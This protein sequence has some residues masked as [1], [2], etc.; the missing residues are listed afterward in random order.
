MEGWWL[1]LIIEGYKDKIISINY[2][3]VVYIVVFCISSMDVKK[4]KKDL[5]K[6]YYVSVLISFQN[7]WKSN[8]NVL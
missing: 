1:W 4:T 8:S 2:F 3:F 5:T 6:K 7:V